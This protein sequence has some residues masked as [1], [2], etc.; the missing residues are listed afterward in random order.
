MICQHWSSVALRVM[1]V[2]LWGGLAWWICP[3]SSAAQLDDAG[4][5]P[6]AEV[7]TGDGSV[8]PA[9]AGQPATEERVDET[10]VVRPVQL[11][12]PSPEGSAP[13]MNPRVPAEPPAEP[14][15]H[16]HSHTFEHEHAHTSSERHQ[17]FGARARVVQPRRAG[18]SFTLQRRDLPRGPHVQTG[19]IL[20]AVPGLQVMQ[21]AGGGKANQYFLRG[22]DADHGTDVALYVDGVPVNSVSHGHGQGY[23]DTHFLIPELVQRVQVSKGPYDPRY[24]DFGTAGA[25][26]LQTTG[27]PVENRATIESGMFHSYRGLALLGGDMRGVRLT[28]AAEILGSDGP[29]DF[30]EDLQRYNVFARAAHRDSAGGELSLTVMGY[31]SSWNASGLLPARAVADGSLG[32]FQYVDR[33]QGGASARHSAYARYRSAESEAQRWELLGYAVA[34]RL[35]LYSNF[36]LFLDNPT[37]G[38]TV[39]QYDE[40]FTSGFKARYERDDALSFLRL[41]S[42]FGAELRD[43]RIDNGLEPAPQK[44]LG[45]PVVD[46]HVNETSISAYVEEEV[47]FTSWLR[48]L[49]AARVDRFDFRVQDKLEDRAT[50][51]TKTS[52]DRSATRVSPK[53]SV[54]VSP[55]SWLDLYGNVGLGFHS[56]DARGVVQGITPLT[57]ALGYEAGSRAKVLDRVTLRATVFRLDLDSELVWVGDAGTTAARGRTRRDGVELDLRVE[58]LSWLWSDLSLTLSRARFVTAPAGERNVPLAP[59]RVLSASLTAAHPLGIFGKLGLTH[60]G[61][62]PASTDG[63]F[64]AEGFTRLDLTTGYRHSRFEVAV[65]VENLTN[66]EWRESQFAFASR[67]REETTPGAC[68]GRSR[69]LLA[70]GAFAGCEDIHFTPGTPLAV[71]G[72]ASLFF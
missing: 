32:R 66:I 67:L 16:T 71:R 45:P 7:A 54:I 15:S 38:D 35:S 18:S 52:G 5:M 8:E 48:T 10:A 12:Q 42:R 64:T 39:H 56:N 51:G 9:D 63:F 44:E 59:T 72:S 47:V 69:P 61:D 55:L 3:S 37:E 29:F 65:A 34:S 57:R 41:T 68:T 40:R 23:A 58:Y 49:G 22:F 36:T 30:G 28:G 14:H 6:D 21:H 50:L 20:R 13:A 46:A 26:D 1:F 11:P 62:R 31:E 4:V 25:I 53:G 43:D 70:Q 17:E 33:T 60:V 24:G 27:G 2:V 19:D